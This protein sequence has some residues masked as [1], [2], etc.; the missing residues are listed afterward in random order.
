MILIEDAK[1]QTRN[2]SSQISRK[3]FNLSNTDTRHQPIRQSISTQLILSLRS[4]NED[5]LTTEPFMSDKVLSNQE[6]IERAAK[7]IDDIQFAMI[8]SVDSDGKLTSCPM[9]TQGFEEFS[10]S[11]WFI[12]SKSSGLVHSLQLNPSVNLSYSDNSSKNYVSVSGSAALVEDTQ[13]LEQMW[14]PF[15]Q[16]YF[17]SPADPDIQLIQITAHSLEY[18][19]SNNVFV[20]IYEM[21]KALATGDKADLG[22][23]HKIDL[24][25]FRWSKKRRLSAFFLGWW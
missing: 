9:T 11:I 17:D 19:I 25:W 16:A 2:L 21:G 8:S 5:I 24:V 12:G 6:H 14:S 10:G 15:Y 23:R 22:E 20:N 18:W 4:N 3:P 7:L 13:K 1:Q